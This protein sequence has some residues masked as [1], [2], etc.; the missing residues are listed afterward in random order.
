MSELRTWPITRSPEAE[1]P[2]L[3]PCK[4]PPGGRV[5]ATGDRGSVMGAGGLGT[6][7]QCDAGTEEEEHN[8]AKF[9]VRGLVSKALPTIFFSVFTWK[10][11]LHI[12]M[13]S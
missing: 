5:S 1:C 12:Q 10:S 3:S 9:L 8:A 6:A 4:A 13:G 7:V 2:Q 11:K